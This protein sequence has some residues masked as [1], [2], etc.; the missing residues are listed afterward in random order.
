LVTACLY[1]LSICGSYVFPLPSIQRQKSRT[2]SKHIH[3]KKYCF[4]NQNFTL[5]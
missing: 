3:V 1:V 5:F 4:L 2:N